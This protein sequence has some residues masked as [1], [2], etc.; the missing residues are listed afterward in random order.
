[1]TPRTATPARLARAFAAGA[2]AVNAVPH[3]VA[4]LSGRRFTS[5]FARPPGRGDSPAPV[6][7]VWS[8]VN[9][10]G[11]VLLARG[12]LA[13]G[14]GAAAFGGGAVAVGLLLSWYFE[15]VRG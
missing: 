15:R 5:P 4:G 11:A 13:D 1:M 14:R 8:A 7:V 6:N 9:A 3:G 2:L 10:G 12:T